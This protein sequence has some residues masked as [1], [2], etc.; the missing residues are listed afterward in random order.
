[1]LRQVATVKVAVLFRE[2][3]NGLIHVGLRSKGSVDVARFARQFGGGGH[4]NASAC[5]ID[6]QIDQ[7]EAV[8]IP[9]LESYIDESEQSEGK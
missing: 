2:D 5:R 3:E 6:G 1:M 4:I 9:S 8:I 7:V